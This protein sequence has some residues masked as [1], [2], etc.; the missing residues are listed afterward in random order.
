MVASG[1]KSGHNMKQVEEG[2]LRRIEQLYGGAGLFKLTLLAMS[3]S[4]QDFRHYWS[5]IRD[6]LN[7]LWNVAIEAL[8]LDP[9]GGAAAL[10]CDNEILPEG[11]GIERFSVNLYQPSLSRKLY[12]PGTRHGWLCYGLGGPKILV[13]HP[14]QGINGEVYDVYHNSIDVATSLMVRGFL[15]TYLFLDYLP[16][17]NYAWR[18]FRAWLLWFSKIAVHSDLVVFVKEYEHGLSRAQWEEAR[19]TPDRVQKKIVEIPGQ[20]LRWASAPQDVPSTTLYFAGEFGSTQEDFYRYEAREA[21]PF[22]EKYVDA[23]LPRD[24][25]MRLD[26]DGNVASYPLTYRLYE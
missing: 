6:I 7:P 25:L 8:G 16:G 21:K 23:D 3:N 4:E 11:P 12:N 1:A 19:L 26:E 15:G 20:E 10:E 22:V 18:G 2:H 24:R 9:S 5:V 17:L 13:S 14:Y